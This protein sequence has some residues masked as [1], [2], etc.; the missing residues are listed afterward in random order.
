MTPINAFYTYL[1]NRKSTDLLA[2]PMRDIVS[3]SYVPREMHTIASDLFKLAFSEDLEHS[4][5]LINVVRL[6]IQ[7]GP[8]ARFLHNTVDGGVDIVD[9]ENFYQ[10]RNRPIADTGT[11]LPFSGRLRSNY[12]RLIRINLTMDG[13][14][15]LVLNEAGSPYTTEITLTDNLATIT[16]PQDN[17]SITVARS[18]IPSSVNWSS[19]PFNMLHSLESNKFVIAGLLQRYIGT[20]PTTLDKLVVE[21]LVASAKTEVSFYAL[22]AIAVLVASHVAKVA[23]EEFL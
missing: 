14:D 8:L 17:C 12:Y 1:T 11:S 22:G 16:F 10:T 18:E 6:S 3:D 5:R 15:L 7:K 9:I 20:V 21:K 2:L 19:I 23:G 13:D 4:Q